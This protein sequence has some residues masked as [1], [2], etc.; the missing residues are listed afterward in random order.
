MHTFTEQACDIKHFVPYHDVSDFLIRK[1]ELNENVK[2]LHGDWNPGLV[3]ILDFSDLN[4][5]LLYVYWVSYV[6]S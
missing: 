4:R 3:R 5:S 1:W 2:E 6:N